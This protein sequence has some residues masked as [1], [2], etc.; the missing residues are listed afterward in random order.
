VM[1]PHSAFEMQL[2]QVP[3][4]MLQAGIE[5]VHRV[6]LLAEQTPQAPPG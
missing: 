2:T 4:A 6:V 1:P 3:L 5:P